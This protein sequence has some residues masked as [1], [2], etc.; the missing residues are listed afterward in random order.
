M[1]AAK[2]KNPYK[3]KQEPPLFSEMY[4]L[5][6]DDQKPKLELVRDLL[7]HELD[8]SE[9]L[10]YY[11]TTWGW[12]PRYSIRRNKVVAA[13]HLLPGLLEGSVSLSTLHL[14]SVRNE[15][16]ILDAHKAALSDDA[17]FAVTK[18]I[19]LELDTEKQIRSFIEIARIKKRFL[20]EGSGES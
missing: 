11:G 17:N 14:E 12:V 3:R 8:C 4:E 15:P 9:D 13:I 18:W 1:K 10:Y 6:R 5:L 20:L 19:T 16:G 2:P 7:M